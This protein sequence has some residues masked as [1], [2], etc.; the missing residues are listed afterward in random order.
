M[1]ER[2]VEM[3]STEEMVEMA[4]KAEG[5]KEKAR[6]PDAISP[7][8]PFL[9]PPP[10]HI[11]PMVSCGLEYPSVPAVFPSSFLASRAL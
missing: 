5:A 9:L 3:S 8:I 2:L 10:L 11:L 4:L 7:S 1:V 6:M